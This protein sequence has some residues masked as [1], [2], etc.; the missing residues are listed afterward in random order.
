MAGYC[1]GIA[2]TDCGKAVAASFGKSKKEKSLA[3]QL[4]L[5]PEN[6]SGFERT[7]AQVCRRTTPRI[8]TRCLIRRSVDFGFGP[9]RCYLEMRE[10][11]RR[12]RAGA[13]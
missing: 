7:G 1:R 3:D 10:L 4:T 8:S 12:C 9:P 5:V 2:A 6:L 11:V 13:L